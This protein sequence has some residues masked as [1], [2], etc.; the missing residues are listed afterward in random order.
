MNLTFTRTRYGGAH[1]VGEDGAVLFTLNPSSRRGSNVVHLQTGLP[2]V[3]PTID[4]ESSSAY[5]FGP[6][7]AKAAQVL[8]QWAA[9]QL[10]VALTV[11][12]IDNT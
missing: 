3:R 7:M 1:G 11:T 6:A 9:D 5:D 10:G 2:G 12:I 8:Q 4:V